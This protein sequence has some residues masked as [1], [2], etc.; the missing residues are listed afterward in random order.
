MA[1]NLPFDPEMAC[2]GH[3]SWHF[4]KDLLISAGKEALL[5]KNLFADKELF[6]LQDP[7]RKEI[8][9]SGREN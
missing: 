5:K 7:D 1:E 3:F 2:S 4:W 6:R 8:L 9:L